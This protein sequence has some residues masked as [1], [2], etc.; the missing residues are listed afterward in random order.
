MSPQI[1]LMGRFPRINFIVSGDYAGTMNGG[2]GE[3]NE[4]GFTLHLYIP[5][6]EAAGIEV[7]R[8]MNDGNRAEARRLIVAAMDRLS[9][10]DAI[11][12]QRARAVV[13]AAFA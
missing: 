10:P 11:D 7:G 6:T 2:A 5:L 9:R 1:T 12:S 8:L 13:A 3:A 4:A